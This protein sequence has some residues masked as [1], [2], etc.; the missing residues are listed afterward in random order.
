[1]KEPSSEGVHPSLKGWSHRKV[2]LTGA[3]GLIGGAV[4]R[5]MLEL[6]Q[7]EEVVC[8]VRPA[9]GRDGLERLKRRLKRAG[10]RGDRADPMMSHVRAVEGDVTSRLWGL[11]KEDLAWIR[12]EAELL[13]HCAASTSFVDLQSCEAINVEGTR[14]MVDV[15]RGARKLKQLVHFSTATV[16]G[17]LPN[18]VIKEEESLARQG[19]HLFAY[20]RTKAEAERILWEVADEIPLLVVRPSITLARGTRDRKQAKLFL[21]SFIAMAQLPYVPVRMEARTDVVTLDFV[22]KSTMRLIARGDKLK[23]NCY[24]LTAGERWAVLGHEAYEVAVAKSTREDLP[25]VVAPE[26]WNEKHEQAIDD[27]GLRSLYEA[28]HLYLPFLNLNLVY[29]NTRLIEELGDDM[30]LLERFPD[31]M[32]EMIATID[33]ELVSS[34]MEEGFGL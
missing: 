2:F 13:I 30:P 22:V 11:S 5:D 21:W 8:L 3:T 16:C 29:D 6:P 12:N 7:V 18:T 19:S 23:Y 32:T 25:T 1:M 34:S 9:E 14:Q 26:D 10:V 20:T 27:Q 15:V 28:L 4:L 24:H 33:P 17:Y 31:Y